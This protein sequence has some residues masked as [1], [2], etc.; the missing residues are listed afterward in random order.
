MSSPAR[1]CVLEFGSIIL[2]GSS[3]IL[4][5]FVWGFLGG[6]SE[7]PRG[8]FGGSSGI[9]RRFLGD[10]SEI[11]RGFLGGSSGIPRGILRGFL[12]G[13]S[14]DPSGIPQVFLPAGLL[15]AFGEFSGSE[16]PLCFCLFAI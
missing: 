4:L 2:A 12:G 3:G 13:S 14:G 15:L 11:P 7:V 9:L 16:V 1:V 6:P 5:G 8:S 10:P